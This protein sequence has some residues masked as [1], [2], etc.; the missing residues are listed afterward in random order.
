MCRGPPLP[1][2]RW[3]PNE[4]S[5]R[6]GPC[7]GRGCVPTQDWHRHSASQLPQQP[8]GPW[9]PWVTRTKSC[10]P[11]GASTNSAHRSKSAPRCAAWMQVKA[12]QMP[13]QALRLP[14]TGHQGAGGHI[15]VPGTQRGSTFT[16]FTH[17]LPCGLHRSDPRCLLQI[18]SAGDLGGR[19]ELTVSGP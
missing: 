9:G 11:G 15:S 18:P 3:E 7:K 14:C 5:Q 8:L 4:K 19:G 17:A 1:R 2:P 6:G 10:D 16:G 12:K 13:K